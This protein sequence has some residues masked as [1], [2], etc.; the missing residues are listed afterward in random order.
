[1]QQLFD[2]SA[3][4]SHRRRAARRQPADFL[5]VEVAR[6]LSDRLALILRPFPVA[7]EIG[8][9]GE[10]VRLAIARP[11]L[12]RLGP[13]DASPD[14]VSRDDLL[15]LGASS[16]DLVVSALAFQFIDDLPGLLVQIRTA[17]RADG[18]MLVAILGGRTLFELRTAFAQAE[19]ELV[20][21]VSPRVIPFVDIRDAGSLL[22]KAG[23]ALPV[24]DSDVLTVRYDNAFALMA[25]LRAMGG[26]NVLIE[27]LRRPTRR[28]VMVRMAEIYAERFSDVDGRIRA[29]FEILWISGW[30]PHES[31]QKPLKPGTAL[32]RLADALGTSERNAG[33]NTNY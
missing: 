27:R 13:T 26:T 32:T 9:L 22:Q 25:D 31:Q 24:T 16:V 23:F 4:V 29:T 33:D 15:P 14:V 28:S 5:L 18:L 11:D 2:K 8:S 30:A 17:L 1:M 12:L 10:H 19:A 21:G 3:L 6:E 7:I 20:G